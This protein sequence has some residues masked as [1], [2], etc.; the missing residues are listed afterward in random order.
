MSALVIVV[1]AEP[2]ALRHTE[3]LLS[4]QGYLVAA[5]SSFVHAKQMLDS[6]TPDL[7]IADL[8][9]E[10]F[11]GLQLAIRSQQDHPDVPVIITFTR[12]DPVAEA[13]A[14]RYG[15]AFI[16]GPLENPDFL[17]CVEAAVAKRRL[18]QAPIRRW[19]RKPIEGVVEVDAA[20]ARAHIVDM[21][22]GGVR[23]AFTDMRQIPT[24]FDITLP[25]IGVTVK[26]RRVWAARSEADD[27]FC[28]G[29]ELEEPAAD[30]WREFVDSLQ[31][32]AAS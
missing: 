18:M 12:E 3:A 21:S 7:L 6:V 27:Q 2:R 5:L 25:P 29:A 1:N 11:N 23:L 15:A 24:T 22:Y 13:E 4:D 16:A 14:A 9:L 31:G 19:F 20:H 8:H 17:P 26:A 30:D 28:C 10:R 32:R